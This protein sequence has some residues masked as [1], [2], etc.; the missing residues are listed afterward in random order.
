MTV[1]ISK[2]NG[3]SEEECKKEEIMK[4][5]KR[6]LKKDLPFG[7]L[8]KGIVLYSVNSGY[9]IS[10]GET[11]YSTGGSSDNGTQVLD[12]KEKEIVDMIWDNEE[13]FEDSTLKHLDF[14]PKRDSIEIRFESMDIDDVIDFTKGLIHILPQ[15]GNKGWTWSKFKNLTTQI[16]NN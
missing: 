10:G 11:F 1:E 12:E 3:F 2:A 9:Q 4:N 7:N 6:R 16:K 14:I 15:M 8:D 13:W 5:Y